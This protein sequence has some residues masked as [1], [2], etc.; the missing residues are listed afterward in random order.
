MRKHPLR[1]AEKSRGP[2]RLVAG[3]SSGFRVNLPSRL[4]ARGQWHHATF[5]SGHSGASAADSHGFPCWCT[6]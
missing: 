2:F 5:V 4:P 3:R 1:P 6:H